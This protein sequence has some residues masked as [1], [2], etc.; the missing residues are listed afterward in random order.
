[1]EYT[2]NINETRTN[3]VQ[4]SDGILVTSTS[5]NTESRHDSDGFRILRKDNK[6]VVL[7]ATENG[8]ETTSIKASTDSKI[9]G[10]LIKKYN[11]HVL[12][13]GEGGN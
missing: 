9:A 2:Q 1:M 3:T 6:E 5:T 13:S 11:G 8:T 4:I 7:R 10:L 12:M